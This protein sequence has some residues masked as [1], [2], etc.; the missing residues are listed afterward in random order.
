MFNSTE[1]IPDDLFYY[2]DTCIIELNPFL[3]GYK[4]NGE[5]FFDFVMQSAKAVNVNPKLL[6]A[7]IQ[8]EQ[9]LLSNFNP[10]LRQLSKAAGFGVEDGGVDISGDWGFQRQIIGCLKTYRTGFDLWK[11]GDIITVDDDTKIITPSNASTYSLY[12]YCPHVGNSDSPRFS[13]SGAY[14][15]YLLWEIWRGLWKN[16]L[17]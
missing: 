11:H 6:F 10:S 7:T 9:G 16:D 17:A 12:R 5:S 1:V 8:R 2:D 4:I 14:G 13:S 3:A 15:V